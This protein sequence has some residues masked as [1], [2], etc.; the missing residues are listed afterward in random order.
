M[1]R[2]KKQREEKGLKNRI[3]G[4]WS[5]RNQETEH[6]LKRRKSWENCG[7]EKEKP[8]KLKAPIFLI[9]LRHSSQS[10]KLDLIV[11]SALFADQQLIY[12]KVTSERVVTAVSM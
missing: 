10:Q 7:G 1:I 6:F 9:L 3:V 12:S 2:R 5:E 4:Q 8:R 11:K